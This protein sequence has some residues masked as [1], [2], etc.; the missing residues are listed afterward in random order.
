VKT[1]SGKRGREIAI[2]DVLDVTVTFGEPLTQSS[3]R[4]RDG[5]APKL[6]ASAVHRGLSSRIRAY[7][8]YELSDTR[9]RKIGFRNRKKPSKGRSGIAA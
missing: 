3:D 5:Q 1:T 8:E 6:T 7:K 4:P 2:H 9:G